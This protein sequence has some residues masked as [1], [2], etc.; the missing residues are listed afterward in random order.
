MAKRRY[1]KEILAPV[2]KNS[3][4]YA[5][6]LKKFGVK[7]TGGMY[8]H[9]KS[10]LRHFHINHSHFTGK[11]WNRGLTYENSKK[12]R[13]AS[14][15]ISRPNSKIFIKNSPPIDS[16]TLRKRLIRLGWK[17]KCKICGISE[18]LGK[19]I[20]LHID[21]INGIHNDNRFKNLRFLCPNCHQQTDTWGTSRKK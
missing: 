20:R 15:K 16:V 13:K 2:V 4:S 8:R 10:L 14:H 7:P 21:H 11:A 5:Q 9:L 19:K 3:Y 17:Y 1:T 18:W 6:V 12:I